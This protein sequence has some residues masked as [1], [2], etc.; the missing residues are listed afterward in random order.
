MAEPVDVP[1]RKDAAGEHEEPVLVDKTWVYWTCW[2]GAWIFTKLYH[3]LRIEGYANLPA[4]GGAVLASNHQ[5][6][7][8]I[9]TI[10]ASN[11][12]HVAF[13]A[14]DTLA[15]WKWLAFTM[16]GCG[17]ILIQRNSSDRK[18]LRAMVQHLE[19]GDLVVIFPEGTRT[20][21]GELGEF[22]GGALLAARMAK[23]PIVPVGTRGAIEAWPRS[24]ALPAPRKIAV[25][26]G[27]P[28]DS[29]LPDA[30]ERLVSVV[31]SM[32]GEGRY[33]SVPP[34]R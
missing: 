24:R 15:H 4:T 31:Q 27:P 26:F 8:D 3:R 14:R 6:H 33:G 34:V 30:Q 23:V 25:R 9:L 1:A 16:R 7:L 17:A 10:A 5:S 19:R 18:A 32:I 11:R 29:A 21:D 20:K 22:K 2:L 13:V 28:I 12:R